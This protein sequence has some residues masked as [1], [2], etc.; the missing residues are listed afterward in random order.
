MHPDFLQ[1]AQADLTAAPGDGTQLASWLYRKWYCGTDVAPARVDN[2]SGERDFLAIL[3]A[4]NPTSAVWTTRW[5]VAGRGRQHIDV[6]WDGVTFRAD[7]DDVRIEPRD[8][9]AGCRVRLPGERLSAAM[10]FYLFFGATEDASPAADPRV[11]LYWHLT[12]CGA[13]LFV[14]TVSTVLNEAGIPFV[15]KTLS[16]PAQYCRAD[17]GVLYLAVSDL[18]RVRGELGAIHHELRP[19]LRPNTPLWTR[20]LRPGLAIACDPG[21]GAS[22]GQM[23]CDVVARAL[24]DDVHTTP[25]TMNSCHRLRRIEAILALSGIDPERPYLCAA[26]SETANTVRNFDLAPSSWR[27]E[28]LLSE[29][30]GDPLQRAAADIGHMVA[31]DAVWNDAQ[32]MCNWMAVGLLP[33]AV[34]TG[35]WAQC[36]RPMGPWR[37]DGL[38]G[39]AELFAVLHHVTGEPQFAHVA[40]GAMSCAL[41]QVNAASPAVS[42][43]MGLLTGL[44]GVWRTAAR[45]RRELGFEFEDSSL[46]RAVLAA[47]SSGWDNCDDVVAGRA[48]V[49]V[50]LVEL[51]GQ[52][53]S[54]ELLQ[55]AVDLGDDLT[56]ALTLP[57]RR[58]ISGMAHGAAGW[59]S[60]LLRLYSVVGET[61]FLG[62]AD[63]AFGLEQSYFEEAGGAF[64]DLRPDADQVGVVSGLSAW[65]VGAPGVALALGSTQAH[66]VLNTRYR[67]LRKQAL[68]AT[69]DALAAPTVNPVTDAGLCHGASG[70]AEVL[71][72]TGTAPA[73]AEHRERAIYFCRRIAS[74]WLTTRHLEF[75]GSHRGNDLSLMLGLSGVAITLLRAG[76]AEVP[77]ALE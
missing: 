21:T 67:E 35:S 19:V 47:A 33:P 10:G 61:R 13:P 65:C 50:A 29:A 43:P 22:F 54:S 46:V 40:R 75:G 42:G 76:G 70:L 59:A 49:I 62:A 2:A 18:P 30:V 7:A 77:S 41:H 31:L 45:L 56:R 69:A 26:S 32:T 51:S 39:V 16:D 66:P 9:Q 6:V 3:S 38:A 34:P 63:A 72:L 60:A 17:A 23:L 58:P 24:V 14:A 5:T 53:G 11:R 1:I 20:M 71:L 25:S 73:F 57:E 4:S 15:A 12:A 36:I 52:S 48:G 28:H 64:P 55:T 44:T 27:T 37:Y 68:D 74:Q 8:P